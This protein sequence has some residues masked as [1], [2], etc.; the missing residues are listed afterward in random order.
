MR[1][2]SSFGW[3]FRWS[4][5]C[6]LAIFLFFLKPVDCPPFFLNIRPSPSFCPSYKDSVAG[7][8]EEEENP[9]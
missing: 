7:R 3:S 4:L 2:A 5:C 1:D 6:L 9:F 8:E